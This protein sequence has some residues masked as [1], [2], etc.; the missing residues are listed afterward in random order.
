L[1]QQRNSPPTV[2]FADESLRGATSPRS[3]QVLLTFLKSFQGSLR[4]KYG[5]TVL[6]ADLLQHLTKKPYGD[7]FERYFWGTEIPEV[8]R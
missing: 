4:W 5:S 8:P 3:D 6:V 2:E 7:F 1:K